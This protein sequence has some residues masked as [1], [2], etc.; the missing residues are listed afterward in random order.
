M[1]GKIIGAAWPTSYDHEVLPCDEMELRSD[2]LGLRTRYFEAFPGSGHEYVVQ[3]G[4]IVVVALDAIDHTAIHPGTVDLSHADFEFFGEAD[5]DNPAIPNMNS[6]SLESYPFGHGMGFQALSPVIF[7][8]EPVDPTTLPVKRDPRN[9]QEYV[10]IPADAILD[11][12]ALR[13]DYDF[14]S[15][16][17]SQECSDAVHVLFDM[18]EGHL[19]YSEWEADWDLAV[20]RRVIPGDS[21]V[22]VVLQRTRTTALDFFVAPRSPGTVP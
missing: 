3:P 8:S 13:Q 14:V 20:H 16:S 2:P 15:R 4:G 6:M 7:V 5:V 11:V 21:L 19:L 9:G 22:R 1:D 18:L 10:R 17:G 12:L